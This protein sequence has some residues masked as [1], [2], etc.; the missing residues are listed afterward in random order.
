VV[1]EDGAVRIKPPETW[2]PVYA[3]RPSD[4]WYSLE[5][6]SVDKFSIQGR[7]ELSRIDR[8]RLNIDRRT[9]AAT[10]GAFSG[11]CNR[12]ASQPGATRF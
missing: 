2:A 8:Y 4:G 6:A 10:F 5:K 11:I 7:L 12:I 9:G 1:L 3:K